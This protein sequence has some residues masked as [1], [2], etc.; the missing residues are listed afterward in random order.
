MLHLN[1]YLGAQ[2]VRQSPTSSVYRIERTLDQARFIAK[3]TRS[4]YPTSVELARLRHEYALLRSFD[5]PSVVRAEALEKCGNGLAL[6]LDDIGERSVQ[7]LIDAGPRPLKKSLE[8]AI[9]VAAAV[10]AV[11]R[12]RVVHK[13]L[14][15]D[16]FMLR[17]DDRTI[18]LIDFGLATRLSL[19]T[20]PSSDSFEGTLAYISPEQTGRMN[21]AV[22]RRSDLYSLGV[23]L[24]ELLTGV[25]PFVA[26]DPLE[27]VHCHLVRTPRQPHEVASLPPVLSRI[28]MKLLAKPAEDR[29]QDAGGLKLDLETCLAT[30]DTSAGIPDFDLARADLSDEL[31][32]PQKLYGRET[33]LAALNASF[34]RVR[35]GSVELLLVRGGSGTGKSALVLELNRALVREG[36]V[37]AGKFDQLNRNVPYAPIV[38]GCRALVRS[39]LAQSQAELANSRQKLVEALGPNARLIVDLVPELEAVIGPQR[40]AAEVGPAEAQRRFESTFAN[41]LQVFA[42]AGHPLVFFLDDLQWADAAS[43]RLLTLFLTKAHASHLLVIGA[44][45]DNELG[46]LHP[47]TIAMADMKKAGATLC[48]IELAPLDRAS[49]SQLLADTLHATLLAV[50]QLAEITVQKTHGNPFFVGQF[51]AALHR[52]G[53]LRLDGV[54][55]AWRWDAAAIARSTVTDNVVELMVSL[56][57]ELSPRA[58]RLLERAACLGHEFDRNTLCVVA[59]EG[60]EAVA[61]DLWE[62]LTLGLIVPLD[63]NYR[64]A[65]SAADSGVMELNASYR[66]LHDRVQQAAYSRIDE[67]DKQAVHLRIGRRLLAAYAGE[68]SGEDL[69][70]VVDHLNIGSPLIADR[71]ERQQLARLDLCAGRRAQGAAAHGAAAGLLGHC[72]ALLGAAA[73]AT[74]YEIALPAQLARAECEFLGG[75]V[76]EALELLEVLDRE[77]RTPFDHATGRSCKMTMLTSMNRMADAIACGVEALAPFGV[78]LPIEP[79]SL[80]PA[81]GAELGAVIAALDGREP[82]ALLELPLM[83]HDDQLVVAEILYKIV[84]AA[85]QANQSLMALAVLR[86]VTLMLQHGNAPAAPQFYCVLGLV[87]GGATGDRLTAF[88]LPNSVS[89]SASGS[90]SR[91]VAAHPARRASPSPRSSRTGGNPSATPSRISSEA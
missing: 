20:P 60:V 84:L 62:A 74:D 40:M 33:Q 77:A 19:E 35:G 50:E 59:E 13:D 9:G 52:Q 88:A 43:L 86:A 79:D 72:L 27:L 7:T 5:L 39:V 71:A 46:P 66:F 23:V 12:Q 14:K 3:L 38:H 87:Y 65:V 53:L 25:R 15:P 49:I 73:W 11:H 54:A 70:R 61:S 26:S 76:D 37:I 47:L 63:H 83:S 36:R 32:I 68:P 6:I 48:E 34:A 57:L 78:V 90:S 24:Y 42:L 21:R 4:E 81:I 41:F 89:R 91:S 8:I 45:R 67:T 44:Y 2:L 18:T 56:F 30:L 28:V 1:D 82:A 75:R 80:G 51:L 10:E 69:F 58:R 17:D 31:R 64:F 16:H 29:Y 85:F 22:D 55:H